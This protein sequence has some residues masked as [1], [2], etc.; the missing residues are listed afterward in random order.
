MSYNTRLIHKKCMLC[1]FH[2]S[3]FLNGFLNSMVL[4]YAHIPT[5][6]I[7]IYKNIF[8]FLYLLSRFAA[9]FQMVFSELSGR[10]AALDFPFRS[11]HS[12]TSI[13]R[14]P[15]AHAFGDNKNHNKKQ[16]FCRK[17]AVK[18]NSEYGTISEIKC[19]IIRTLLIILYF[20]FF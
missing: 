12:R 13:D 16:A 10:P 20:V 5:M 3:P 8:H 19:A 1:T 14:V 6:S 7:G 11:C 15:S 2:S 9:F 18:N 4:I 17:P